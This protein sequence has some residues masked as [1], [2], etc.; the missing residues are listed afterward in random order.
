M[1]T[2]VAG[3]FTHP[4][5]EWKEIR[6]T[7]ESIG[8][9]YF[10]HILFLAL[11]PP[12]SAYI[13]TTRIGWVVGSG[14]PTMLTESSALSMSILTYMTM[15]AGVAI[16]GAFIKW[17]ALT[18]DSNPS[19]TR[20]TVFAAYTATPMFIAGLCMLYPSPVLIMLVGTIAVSYTAYLL[21]TGISIFMRIPKMEGFVFASSVLTAGLVLLVALMATTVVIWGMGFGPIYL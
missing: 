18:Y 6:D 19:Y 4:V 2:H 3:L 1:I 11:I 17:M 13:G 20:C 16:M 10:A 12:V 8:H 15:L 21:Y 7:N 14:A 9:L 5:K